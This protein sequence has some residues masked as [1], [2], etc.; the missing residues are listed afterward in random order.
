MIKL[1]AP[2]LALACAAC[3]AQTAPQPQP[4]PEALELLLAG[5]ERPEPV[6]AVVDP[7]DRKKAERLLPTI[8]KMSPS[9]AQGLVR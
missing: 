9:V 2:L 1:A 5:L 6:D 7:E 4:D 3:A 8:E